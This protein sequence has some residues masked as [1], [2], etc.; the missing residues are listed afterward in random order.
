MTD[1]GYKTALVT[2]ASRGI[3][4]AMVRDLRRRGYEVT[5]AARDAEALSH[6][7][8][9]TGCRP[10][11]LDI[12]DGA[13]VEAALA[14]L[15]IDV[16][17]NNAG[18]VTA[19]KPFIQCS[20]ADVDRQIAVN[21]RGLLAVTHALLPGMVARGRGHLFMLTSLIA[22]HP[23][24]NATIY[25]ATKAGVHAF[26]QGLRLELAGS[27]VRVSEIAPGRVDT[28]IY[29]EAF[30][31]DGDALRDKLFSPFRTLKPDNVS[32]ALLAAL[33]LPLHVDANLIELSPSDQ[34]VGGSVFAERS[35]SA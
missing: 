9:E 25:A 17:V 31:G 15:D 35:N 28:G 1:H 19:V 21:L 23:F 6:L 3:G 13:A 22:L 8:R 2:G 29:L 32:A 10:L 30:S 11:P 24:P 20:M 18:I 12:T 16:L 4:A 26:A 7:A 5:A 33:A 34:A 14:G 27:G